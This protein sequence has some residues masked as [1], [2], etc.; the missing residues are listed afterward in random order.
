MNCAKCGRRMSVYV[1]HITPERAR[2]IGELFAANFG[3]EPED[4]RAGTYRLHSCPNC[5]QNVV[6]APS[7]N[8]VISRS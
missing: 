6:E 7:P 5:Q 4:A 8:E 1:R 3:R 2:E